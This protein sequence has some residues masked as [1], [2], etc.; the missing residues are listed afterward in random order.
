MANERKQIL[1]SEEAMKAIRGRAA[2]EKGYGSFADRY[3]VG[4]GV[5][6]ADPTTGKK[7]MYFESAQPGDDA[8]G[9]ATRRLDMQNSAAYGRLA[10]GKR[11]VF[12]GKEEVSRKAEL[13][14]IFG[15]ARYDRP[16]TGPSGSSGRYHE[17][18][19]ADMIAEQEAAMED[20]V[21]AAGVW[22]PA[23]VSNEVAREGVQRE[24]ATLQKVMQTPTEKKVAKFQADAE[25][26]VK[27]AQLT[28][29]RGR[30]NTPLDNARAAVQ[31]RNPSLNRSGPAVSY[32]SRATT[33]NAISKIVFGEGGSKAI[34]DWLDKRRVESNMPP[35]ITRPAPARVQNQVL[36]SIFPKVKN[37]SLE[38]SRRSKK[39]TE[40]FRLLDMQPGPKPV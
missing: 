15:E 34:Q 9:R 27:S 35:T 8:E 18:D 6:S 4:S 5:E 14:S 2:S 36:R 3:G 22:S 28:P 38:D 23:Q 32:T 30:A 39:A 12:G 21:S 7:S 37:W 24:A 33:D 16:L 40:L 11:G 25:A 29:T 10:G 26:F 31:D 13:A 1:L 20:R 17:A 19:A